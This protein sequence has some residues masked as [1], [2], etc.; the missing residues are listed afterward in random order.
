MSFGEN[1]VWAYKILLLRPAIN[2]KCLHF[3]NVTRCSCSRELA[4]ILWVHGCESHI[5][6]TG[7]VGMTTRGGAALTWKGLVLLVFTIFK[8]EKNELYIMD[9]N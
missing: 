2:S 5:L 3:T 7:C 1:A 4:P 9:F 8:I 6:G